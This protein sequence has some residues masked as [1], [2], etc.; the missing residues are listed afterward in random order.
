MLD[1][2]KTGV[3]VGLLLGG[4]H[5]LWS[6]LVAVGWGQP[7]I[8]LVLWAHMVHLQYVVGPFEFTAAAALVLLTTLAGYA[9]G[10]LFAFVWNILH[11]KVQ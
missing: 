1:R 11:Q 7:L 3:A 6:L 8:D 10:W 9:F 4:W 2:N 5:L